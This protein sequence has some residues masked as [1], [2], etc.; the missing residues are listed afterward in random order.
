MTR[1]TIR[2]AFGRHRGAEELARA[3]AVLTDNGFAYFVTE[4]T[5]GR[6][7]QRWFA[8]QGPRAEREES[9]E[10]SRWPA[11]GGGGYRA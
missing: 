8:G 4:R 6:P 11:T 3:L 10:R 7:A 9:A 2:D 5:E 1:N